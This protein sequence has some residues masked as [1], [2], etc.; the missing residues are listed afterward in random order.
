MRS[1][2]VTFLGTSDLFVPHI[3]SADLFDP[4]IGSAD[5]AADLCFLL[6][7]GIVRT[8]FQFAHNRRNL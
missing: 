6:E 2:F 3:G 7:S 5:D 8:L 1:V 4:H